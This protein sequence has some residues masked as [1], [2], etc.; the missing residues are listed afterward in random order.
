M[1]RDL[2]GDGSAWLE[3]QRR[4]HLSRPVL[5]RRG[6]QTAR[7]PATVGRTLFAIAI[8]GTALTERV[9][10]RDYL[11]AASDLAAFGVP[12]RGDQVVEIAPDGARH[13][14]EVLAPGRDPHWRWADPNRSCY[15]IHTK[16]IA[17]EAA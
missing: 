3:R 15:R 6:A 9:V 2:I 5:Y 10:S 1:V 16:H 12:Q 7:V 8:A 17:T 13:V 4:A 11:I 14:H